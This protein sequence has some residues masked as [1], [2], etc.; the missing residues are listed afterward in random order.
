MLGW[1]YL[2]WRYSVL[3]TT[4]LRC[5]SA[6]KQYSPPSLIWKTSP[7]EKTKQ[8]QQLNNKSKQFNNQN[9]LAKFKKMTVTFFLCVCVCENKTFV[10]IHRHRSVGVCCLYRSVYTNVYMMH[11]VF[12][13]FN[14]CHSLIRRNNRRRKIKVHYWFCLLKASANANHFDRNGRQCGKEKWLTQLFPQENEKRKAKYLKMLK[15][16]FRLKANSFIKRSCLTGIVFPSGWSMLTL[17]C[18]HC[19]KRTD[20]FG[21]ML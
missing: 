20:L 6:W 10:Y 15:I 3:S 9:P 18:L 8:E 4:T 21:T 14:P 11:V 7:T 13:S 17:F 16:L 2:L 1:L 19:D 12:V 5:Q